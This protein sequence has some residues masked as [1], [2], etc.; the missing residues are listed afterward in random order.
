[1]GAED[2]ESRAGD[3]VYQS[4][5]ESGVIET[6]LRRVRSDGWKVV[7]AK[8][9][10]R[11]RKFKSHGP[12][13]GEERNVLGLALEAKRAGA[14]ILAFVRDADGDTARLKTIDAA[15][16][17]A[18]EIFSDLDIIGGAAFPVLEAWLLAMK[19]THGTE[20]LS[21]AAAQ[22]KLQEMGIPPKDTAAMVALVEGAPIEHGDI[23]S[24]PEDAATLR[25]WI[26]RAR[27]VL[28]SG[29]DAL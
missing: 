6:L 17:K 15:V 8:Q 13:P 3:P 10:C 1:M 29:A 12:T 21:K 20:S 18:A 25:A 22:S 24:L 7:A 14:E 5:A 26:G 2:V 11:S 28:L 23:E 16:A 27:E 4:A 19:H 9:W